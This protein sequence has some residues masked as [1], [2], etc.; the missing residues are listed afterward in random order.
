MSIQIGTILLVMKKCELLANIP[1][2][3]A[4]LA[5]HYTD[6]PKHGPQRHDP[7]K[8]IFNYGLCLA[9]TC[10]LSSAHGTAHN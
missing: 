10:A 4:G 9:S 3:W 1:Y 6:P 7:Q 5:R 8:Y 2:M